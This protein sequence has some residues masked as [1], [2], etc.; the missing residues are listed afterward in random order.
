MFYHNPFLRSN[1]DNITVLENQVEDAY[2]QDLSS[3]RKL[4]EAKAMVYDF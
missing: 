3:S 4:T 2:H 1:E